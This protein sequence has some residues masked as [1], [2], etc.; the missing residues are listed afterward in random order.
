M[1]PSEFG[2][3]T[4]R[5]SS[6]CRSIFTAEPPGKPTIVSIVSAKHD[7]EVHWTAPAV[8]GGRPIRSY[9]VQLKKKKGD[10]EWTDCKD[11]K[12]DNKKPSCSF[13]EVESG[14]DYVVRVIA[15][16]EIGNSE[17]ATMEISTKAKGMYIHV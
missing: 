2:L 12:Q 8:D 10:S 3:N 17:P 14:T 9:I 7:I 4:W 1:V 6:P 13:T 5:A 11:I 16:N 15:V